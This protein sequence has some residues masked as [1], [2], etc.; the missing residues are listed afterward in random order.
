MDVC[1]VTSPTPWSMESDVAF[2]ADHES[3]EDPPGWMET[4][5]AVKEEIAGAFTVTVAVAVTDPLLLVAVKVYVVVPVGETD[6][7]VCPVTFPTP[8]SI[9]KEVALETDHDRVDDCPAAMLVG[10]A[11]KEEMTGA[12]VPSLI[13]ATM[14]E[15]LD[16]T[17]SVAVA[18]RTYVPG[19]EKLAIHQ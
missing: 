8:R 7:E 2:D 5:L 9:L 17:P 19:P 16:S 18:R 10:E 13:V 14:S 11:V 3:V 15:E 4:G 1:P 6:T 12:V